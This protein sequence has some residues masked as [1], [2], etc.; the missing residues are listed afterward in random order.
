MVRVWGSV[1]SKSTG[2]KLWEIG[3]A[4]HGG[5][6]RVLMS[7]KLFK[8]RVI[9]RDQRSNGVILSCSLHSWVNDPC[10]AI[11]IFWFTNNQQMADVHSF[12]FSNIPGFRRPVFLFGKE[13][14]PP[15]H[16]THTHNTCAHIHTLSLHPL[17]LLQVLNMACYYPNFVTQVNLTYFL[18]KCRTESPPPPPTHCHCS[19]IGCPRKLSSH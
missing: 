16:T 9:P 19:N 10:T 2:V 8:A 7:A 6:A 12:V 15:K 1:L 4:E 5:I 13:V 17:F 18:Y 11:P 3:V 14:W